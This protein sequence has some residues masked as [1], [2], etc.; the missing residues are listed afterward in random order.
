M[1]IATLLQNAKTAQE[2]IAEA[3][4]HVPATRTCSCKDA[5]KSAI[6]THAELI[7]AATKKELEPII[8]RYM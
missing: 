3:V 2:L 4:S 8:G 5:L 1:V 7:P 6:I